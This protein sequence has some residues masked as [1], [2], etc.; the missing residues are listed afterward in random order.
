MNPRFAG[1]PIA[2]LLCVLALEASVR[3]PRLSA[4]EPH[5]ANP[6]LKLGT[7]TILGPTSCPEGAATGASCKSARVSCSGLPDLDATLGLT[8]PSGTAKG[9]IVLVSGGP[10]TAFFNSGF[11][12]PY[13][14]NGFNVVQLAWASAWESANGAGVKDAAC[15]PASIFKYAFTQVQRQSRTGG[16]CGQGSSGGG[17]ALAYSLSEYGMWNYFDYVMIAAGP[18]VSRM[19]YG[20]DP[21][22]YIGG[23]RDLCPLLTSAPFAYPSGGKINGYE[24]TTTCAKPDPL[25]SDIDKWTAD[26]TVSDG[27]TYNYPQTAMSWFFCVTPSTLNESTGQGTFLI[28]KV[29]PKNTPPDVNCYSGVCQGEAVWTDPTAFSMALSEMLSQCVTNHCGL[30]KSPERS[31]GRPLSVYDSQFAVS[32]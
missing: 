27:A 31:Q 8:R 29:I 4:V 10:G 5:K 23:P 15:R 30:K 14:S 20:C 13:V 11:A 9:T 2:L 32:V 1:R 26:S 21:S 25:A 28:E 7:V 3:I 6:D 16:F 19:D 12:D 22:L 24:G 17:A 18:G